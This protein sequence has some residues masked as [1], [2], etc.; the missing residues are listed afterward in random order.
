MGE[1]TGSVEY[2][3]ELSAKV[4]RANGT[5][6]DLGVIS[7]AQGV[8]DFAVDARK[9]T[10]RQKIL[11]Y[12]YRGLLLLVLAGLAYA[13]GIL[14]RLLLS[15]IL[16]FGLVTTVGVNYMAADFAAGGTTPHIGGL[17]FHDC[18]TGTT[19]AN[20]TDTALVTPAGTARVAG[21]QT[22]PG[23]VNIYRSV[24]TISFTSGLA[25]TEWGLFSAAS[26]GTLWDRR[27]FSAINV[28]SGDS[29]A[30]TYNLTINSGGT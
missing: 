30:F 11:R 26:V 13:L 29:I 28:V 7:A 2:K 17:N 21:T 16:V 25:I 4:I 20:V 6:E 22:Q 18:G 5:V 12:A 15:L 14:A 10:R 9:L 3:G 8:Q 1:F 27:V 24:A 23:T 19:A